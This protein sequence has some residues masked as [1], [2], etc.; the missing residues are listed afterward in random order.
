MQ[1]SPRLSRVPRLVWLVAL[2]VL[3]PLAGRWL[4]LRAYPLQYRP[5]IERYALANQIDPMVVMAVIRNES[6]FEKDARSRQGARGLMQIMPETGQWIANQT[7]IPYSTDMLW[8]PEYNIRLGCWYLDNLRDE[9]GGDQV[10]ALAAYNAGRSNVKK[11]LDQDR[12]TGEFTTLGQ[13][14]FAETRTYVAKVL[15]DEKI[16][17]WIYGW[18][19]K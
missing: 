13:I 12:W 11:W 7:N 10:V 9:F 6:H 15:R 14:P 4:L 8:D 19:T 3:V 1:R 17:R 16:Y 18:S 5:I 2:L